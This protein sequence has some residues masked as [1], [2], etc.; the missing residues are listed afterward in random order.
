MDRS[1]ENVTVLITGASM[2]VGAAAARAFAARGANLVLIARGEDRLRAL[3]KALDLGDRVHVAAM[4][5]TDLDAF[6]ALLAE[7]EQ[8]FG[9]VDVLVNNA[10]YH[11]RGPVESVDA[12]ELG[13]MIDVN[14]K[15]PIMATRLALPYL[16]RAR[17]PAVINVASLAGRTP[18]PGSATYSAS[19]FGLRAFGLALHEEL[20]G[21]G[22][23]VASVSPGPIDTGF[24]MD[25]IDRVTDLT[26]SQPIVTAEQVAEAIV[27]L[28]DDATLDRPMPRISGVLTTVSYLFPRVGRA[29]RPMLE[30]KGRKTKDRLKRERGG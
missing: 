24:I 20:R 16:R 6:A 17:R 19:K 11:A 25:D 26:F 8:R 1:F 23:K 13:R 2:G 3:D 15:A 4:D 18:V 12:D 29:L 22:I 10:G 28:V 14:L 21:E 7:T 30:K 27:A 5:V 9:S